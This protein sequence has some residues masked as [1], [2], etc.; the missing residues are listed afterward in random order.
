MGLFSLCVALGESKT[1]EERVARLEDYVKEGRR[2]LKSLRIHR[3]SSIF[4]GD[5]FDSQ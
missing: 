1:H 3:F 2:S 5:H 4:N